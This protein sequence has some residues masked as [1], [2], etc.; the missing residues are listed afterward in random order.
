M[1]GFPRHQI[2]NPF[3]WRKLEL[4][5]EMELEMEMGMRMYIKIRKNE[6]Q[7]CRAYMTVAGLCGFDGSSR[8]FSLSIP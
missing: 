7:S 5:L 8:H 6:E 2:K 1:N 3:N 4:E